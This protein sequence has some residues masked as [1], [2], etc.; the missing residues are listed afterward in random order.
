MSVTLLLLLGLLVQGLVL[1]VERINCTLL[2]PLDA[3]SAAGLSGRWELQGCDIPVFI[4]AL[5]LDADRQY[6]SIRPTSTT[7]NI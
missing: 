3:L 4:E 2:L 7:T 1:A 6:W 5:V